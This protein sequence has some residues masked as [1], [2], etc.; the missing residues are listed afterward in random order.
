MLLLSGG[1]CSCL[2]QR[3][4]KN[5]VN[6]PNSPFSETWL[7]LRR[8]VFSLSPSTLFIFLVHHSHP[9]HLSHRSAMAYVNDLIHSNYHQKMTQIIFQEFFIDP[10]CI[11]LLSNH[12]VYFSL[13]I[14]LICA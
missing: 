8:M 10:L 6:S 9:I 13:F 12:I 3:N 5:G 4:N 1:V 14:A 2:G 11:H 7:L